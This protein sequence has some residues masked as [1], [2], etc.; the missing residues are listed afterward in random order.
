MGQ[1][2]SHAAN[3]EVVV[4]TCARIQRGVTLGQVPDG[5]AYEQVRTDTERLRCTRTSTPRDFAL[6]STSSNVG[7]PAYSEGVKENGDANSSEKE[8]TGTEFDIPEDAYGAAILV[9]VKDRT[10]ILRRE[11]AL[12][13]FVCC[14]MALGLLV[15]NLVLQTA[16]LMYVN[17]YVV[18]PAVRKVQEHY[19]D[20][21]IQVYS[22]EGDF[23]LDQWDKY[24]GK[25][26]LCE[27]A[28][29][30][31]AFYYSILFCWTVSMLKEIRASERL[32]RDIRSM[33]GAF[34]TR[35]MVLE[36]DGNIF[37]VALTF[38]TRMML[39]IFVCFPKAMI[40]LCLLWLGC[41]WL[42]A[43]TSFTDLVMNAVAMEFVTSVDNIL[44]EAALP[45]WFQE[46]VA[47]INFLKR[48]PETKKSQ[49]Q[50]EQDKW[51]GIRRSTLYLVVACIYIVIYAE[52]LQNVLPANLADV[53]GHCEDFIQ[54]QRTPV[55]WDMSFA[56]RDLSRVRACYPFGR[57]GQATLLDEV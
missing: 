48:A 43:T 8:L 23:N 57:L 1:L 36:N 56:L 53:S 50:V 27:I 11:S 51:R 6:V 32:L 54:T 5:V 28:L 45:V 55:C 33:E 16:I 52:C 3:H 35:D 49:A 44:Y 14:A 41:Q 20:F 19:A 9:I 31:R 17:Y 2:I 18:L 39:Y 40:S 21:H 24:E 10:K 15:V 26:G 22:D 13:S 30:N 4:R 7:E 25:A 47:N 37:I 29:T 42:S 34:D 12:L 46:E 38:P